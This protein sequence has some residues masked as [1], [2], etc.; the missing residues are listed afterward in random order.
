MI[1]DVIAMSNFRKLLLYTECRTYKQP[2]EFHSCDTF[3]STERHFYEDCVLNMDANARNS[4]G[5]I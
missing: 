3:G 5:L 2:Y 4:E 1:G